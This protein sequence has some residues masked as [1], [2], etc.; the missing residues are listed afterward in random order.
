[1]YIMKNASKKGETTKNTKANHVQNLAKCD[2]CGKPVKGWGEDGCPV[3]AKGNELGVL[4][5]GGIEGWRH[6]DC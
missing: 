4:F 1:M 5:G 3:V 6:Y 2:K